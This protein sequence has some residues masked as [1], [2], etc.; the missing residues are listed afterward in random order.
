MTPGEFM[1][2]LANGEKAADLIEE[3]EE[4]AWG[5]GYDAAR[6]EESGCC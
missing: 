1:L 4:D 2:R 5:R 3:I 6:H